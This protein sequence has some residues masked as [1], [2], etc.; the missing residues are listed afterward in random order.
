[1]DPREALERLALRRRTS[2]SPAQLAAMWH[3]DVAATSVRMALRAVE[4]HGR[5]L[6]R[7]PTVALCGGVFQNV[8]LLTLVRHALVARGLTVL[9]PRTLPAN[10]GAI[11]IGQAAVAAA[12]DAEHL[13]AGRS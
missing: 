1:V 9:E 6:G 2:V 5:A 8:R 3:D 11:A 7:T 12:L 4:E 10:D 13:N